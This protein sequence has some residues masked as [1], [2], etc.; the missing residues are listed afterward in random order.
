MSPQWAFRPWLV[1][2]LVLLCGALVVYLY[3]AQRQVAPR[4]YV[5]VLTG[6]RVLL[7][8]L[9][10]VL[11]AGLSVRWTRTGS[12][13]GTLWVVVD[14]SG[15][16]ALAD[17]QATPAE[18]LR[19]ADALGHLPPDKRPGGLD[20]SAARLT[21]VRS[22]LNHL[23]STGEL[24]TDGRD[25]KRDVERYAAALRAWGDSVRALADDVAKDPAGADVAKSLRSAATR[26]NGAEV[27]Q[28]PWAELAADLD[29]A[30]AQLR[31]IADESIEKFLTQHG[32]D[33]KVKEALDKVGKMTR[34]E[35]AHAVLSR[36]KDSGF[37][38]AL[39]KQET[40]LLTFADAP[41]PVSFDDNKE[42][43][44]ALKSAGAPAGQ[45]TN[46]A[47]PLRHVADQLGQDE[48]AAVVVVS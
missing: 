40:K 3:R 19:W 4:R 10:F 33:P 24:A 46:L 13:G 9:A 16:M 25:A 41:H 32:S 38:E 18:K 42:L 12:S 6:L 2:L 5:A 35:L 22:E 43:A 36:A 39:A 21:A 11:L 23:R 31:K 1:V 7:V 28:V 14:G 17:P 15:S 8:L 48:P 44:G 20:A 34:A 45:S 37:G 30:L 27:K 26:M 29:P 47:A